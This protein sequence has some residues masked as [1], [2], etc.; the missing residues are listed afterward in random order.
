MKRTDTTTLAA[1]MDVLARE[2]QSGDGVANLAIQEAADR[3]RELERVAA[4]CQHALAVVTE[5]HGAG[6]NVA[7]GNAW[8]LCRMAEVEARAA[9]GSVGNE[10]TATD[11]E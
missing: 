8:H 9:M 4:K 3:L 10:R 7:V 6:K 2:I 1:A 5:P 11:G